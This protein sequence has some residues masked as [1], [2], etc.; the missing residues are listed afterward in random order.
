M[1][2]K[3]K[4]IEYSIKYFF[5]KKDFFEHS[6]KYFAQKSTQKRPK[7]STY[8]QKST[9]TQKSTCTQKSTFTKKKKYF[10][11]QK[12][13]CTKKYILLKK[14]LVLKKVL[15]CLFPKKKKFAKLASLMKLY[16]STL[17]YWG[18]GSGQYNCRTTRSSL[19]KLLT[20]LKLPRVSF[21]VH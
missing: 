20:T 11:P 4:K 14:I 6:K 7:K 1:L 5:S 2:L 3:K 13:T 16:Y 15:F 9:F 12:S 19:L 10:F 21:C 8:T 17:L 18:E